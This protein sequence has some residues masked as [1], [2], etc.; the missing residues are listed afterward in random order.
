MSYSVILSELAKSDIADATE[1][2]EARRSGLGKAF[3]LCL[4]DTFE[5]I[6]RNPYIYVKVYNDIHR[7][8]MNKFPYALF[9]RIDKLSNKVTIY[10]LL[11]TYRDPELWKNR[12]DEIE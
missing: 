10:T 4:K 8:L 7:A 3:L 9:Y 2:Y 11:S 6:A 12:I 5:I 1:Y